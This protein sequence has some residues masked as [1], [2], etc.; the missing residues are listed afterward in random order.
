MAGTIDKIREVLRAKYG[1]WFVNTVWGH[2]IYKNIRRGR[3]KAPYGMTRLEQF[4]EWHKKRFSLEQKRPDH[5]LV[6]ECYLSITLKRTLTREEVAMIADRLQEALVDEYFI[7]EFE[8]KNIMEWGYDYEE[9]P[10][11]LPTEAVKR[12]SRNGEDFTEENIKSYFARI[13]ARLK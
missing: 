12:Y 13:E 6:L 9:S 7:I 1:K 5:P 8:D 10:V 11:E 2:L 4:L 3:W